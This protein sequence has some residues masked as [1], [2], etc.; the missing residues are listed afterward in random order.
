MVSRTKLPNEI[1]RVLDFY[2]QHP[3]SAEQILAKVEAERGSLGGLAP[4]D[5]YPHDQDH[6]GGL[7]ANDALH[8]RAQIGEGSRVLDLCAGLAGPARYCAAE[9]GA[10]VTATE[11]NP[12]RAAGA[13]RLNAL[14][15]MADRVR[16]V[17]GDVQ[18]LPF[19][20]ASFDAV[21]GQEAF[22]HIPD[23]KALFA[24][25]FR[26][27]APG[28]RI[29][30]TDWIAKQG[31]S[32][33]DRANLRAGIAAVGIETIESYRAL[34]AGAGF[35]AIEAE[36]LSEEWEP[37]LRERLGMYEGLREE[38]KAPDGSDPHAGY[39]AVYQYF[40]DLVS[41][42]ALGGGRFSATR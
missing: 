35:Q 2:D 14:T 18:A 1:A 33:K 7:A 19:E 29:A 23:K 21:L 22:L 37:I 13:E 24:E 11:L 27:L 38:A 15:G 4:G 36:D 3:I 39:V 9:R 30:F 6:Y 31:L 34:L 28:G 16:V 41:G 42:G 10:S 12:G 20:D 25:A 5:L 26:V 8:A 40:V 17:R 32:D